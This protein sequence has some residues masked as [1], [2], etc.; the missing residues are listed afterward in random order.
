MK[1]GFRWFFE[2]IN[3]LRKFDCLNEIDIVKILEGDVGNVEERI[4]WL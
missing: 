2:I 1:E 3:L 4:I